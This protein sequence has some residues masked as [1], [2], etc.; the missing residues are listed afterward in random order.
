MKQFIEI[1]EIILN[2][3]KEIDDGLSEVKR[4][5]AGKNHYSPLTYA[6]MYKAK[7]LA[8]Q[9]LVD[10]KDSCDGKRR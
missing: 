4:S 3:I 6:E 9:A 10:L 8:L 5:F 7:S 1:E 2:H